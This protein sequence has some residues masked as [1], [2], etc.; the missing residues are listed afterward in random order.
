[1]SDKI[2][3]AALTGL[4]VLVAFS[5]W[6]V[7]DIAWFSDDSLITF[8]Y[9]RNTL[10]GLGPVFNAGEAVQGY[11]H[12][13]WFLLLLPGSLVFGEPIFVAIGYGILLTG[14][15]LALLAAAT[16]RIA[17]GPLIALGVFAL[18][19][20]VLLASDAWL[21]FQTGGLE[22]SLSHLL[23]V[24]VI[25]ECRFNGNSRPA[26]IVL[27]VTLLC[28]CRP[29]FF[30]FGLPFGLFAL[31]GV[32]NRGNA[33]QVALAALPGLLW[34]LFARLYYGNPLPNTATA[35]V[36]VYPEIGDA[37]NQGLIY[38]YD[39]FLYEPVAVSGILVLTIGTVAISRDRLGL[40]VATGILLQIGWTIWI[41]GDFMRG[42]FFVA[43]LTAAATLSAIALAGRFRQPPGWRNPGC[44]HNAA[45]CARRGG[46]RQDRRA[47]YALQ[48]ACRRKRHRQ[49]A[50][51]LRKLLIERIPG[52]QG[53]RPPDLQVQ[54]AVPAP[55]QLH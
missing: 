1:M 24:L 55:E 47:R 23:I 46:V 7:F 4:A 50:I 9:V 53:S 6:A 18:V 2:R 25:C 16:W 52:A 33:L 14:A 22:N 32:R 48:H 26:L 38:L 44:R 49:R 17:N 19:M 28:L 41:G 43:P 12:P 45:R 35:K 3:L 37:L 13:L 5:V 39:W 27:L 20:T 10:A 15:T 36:G 8:R 42:R 51:L 21:S 30:F 29:D 34:L 54:P 40:I 11:T 31:T